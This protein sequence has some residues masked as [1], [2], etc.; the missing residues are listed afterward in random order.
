MGIISYPELAQ[1]MD[2]GLIAPFILDLENDFY[3]CFTPSQL[4]ISFFTSVFRFPN[5]GFHFTQVFYAFPTQ[6]FILHKCF[7]FSQPGISFFT[8]VLCFPNLGFHFTQLFFVFPTWDFIFHKCFTFSHL[9]ISF[10]TSVLCY[11]TLGCY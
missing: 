9:G 2:Q 11:P 6:D 3:K 4:G 7:S 1:I 8:S 10:F 5:L